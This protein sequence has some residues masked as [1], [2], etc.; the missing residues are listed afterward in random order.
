MNPRTI[1]IDGHYFLHRCLHLPDLAALQTQDG[2]KTGGVFGVVTSIKKSLET[3]PTVRHCII[4]WDTGRSA[5]RMKLLPEYKAN[6]DAQNE[7]EKAEK[8][9]YKRLF[10]GQLS[11]LQENL[12]YLGIRQVLLNGYEGDD[13]IGWIVKKSTDPVVVVTEDKDL[14]Q[15]VGPNTCLWMPMKDKLV[16]IDTFLDQIGVPPHLFLMYKA[17]LGDPSDN[18]PGIF[19]VGPKTI[20]QIIQTAAHWTPPKNIEEAED[21]LVEACQCQPKT[22][23]KKLPAKVQRV[24]D[25]LD[26]F[27]LNMDMMDI[28]QE[29][30]TP[31]AEAVLETLSFGG[32]HP[33]FNEQKTVRFFGEYEFNTL[34]QWFTQVT[35]LFRALS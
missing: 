23:T 3:F 33:H 5:R 6:R 7:E 9:E 24:L 34:L 8:E 12:G 2:R 31:G 25:S 14:L 20:Q 16:T 15:V 30:F 26:T 11:I 1:V 19:Q 29:S 13:L 4:T 35:S 17:L 21:I 22:K 27:R 10:D 28:Y 18:I 32:R